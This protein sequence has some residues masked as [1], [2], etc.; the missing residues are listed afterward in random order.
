MPL[1]KS[2]LGGGFGSPLISFAGSN[3][4]PPSCTTKQRAGFTVTTNN[5]R[6]RQESERSDSIHAPLSAVSYALPE[7]VCLPPLQDV[8]RLR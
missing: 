6:I 4:V 7:F 1:E 3:S 5:E 8:K 2:C